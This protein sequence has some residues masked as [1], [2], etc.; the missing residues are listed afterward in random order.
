MSNE[1]RV[2]C[3]E[4]RD[5]FARILEAAGM[6]HGNASLCARL[7]ADASR[8]GVA[9]H[10][11]NRFA[12]FVASVRS[13][14]VKPNVSPILAARFNALERYDGQSGPGP[15][16]AHFAMARACALAGEFGIGCVALANT[17]H[18]MRAGNFGWQ[19]AD[20]DRLG[21]CF[22]NGSPVMPPW[23]AHVARLGNNP[24]VIAVPRPHGRHIVLDMALSQYSWGRLKIFQRAGEQAPLPAGYT[25]EGQLTTDPAAILHGGA[26][27]PIGHWKGAGLA[28]LVDIVVASLAN[29]LASCHVAKREYD[30]GVSQT[31]IAIHPAAL[32]T[33]PGPIIDDVLADVHATPPTTPGT[34]VMH[35]GE[36]TMQTREQSLR[37]GVVVD[38]DIWQQVCGMD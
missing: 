2:P 23:G 37:E 30:H 1:L 18:W 22:T 13:G 33:D 19:A 9:S 7:F 25:S 12:G 3:D 16:N 15:S 10:G 31:F 28:L 29:G 34:A 17:N 35:P 21:I 5:T 14:Q 6:Q 26:T 27:L 38:A 36:R 11:L 20:A 24:L 32:G 8:D 4:L